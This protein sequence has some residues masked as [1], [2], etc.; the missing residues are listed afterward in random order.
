[1]KKKCKSGDQFRR[2][3]NKGFEAIS[4]LLKQIRKSYT[5]NLTKT[6]NRAIALLKVPKKLH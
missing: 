1:M 6:I 5:L 4:Y 2:N 3:E